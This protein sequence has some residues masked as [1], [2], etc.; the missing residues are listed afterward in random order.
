M[1]SGL[2][3]LRVFPSIDCKNNPCEPLM[4]A[5]FVQVTDME[6]QLCTELANTKHLIQ[7]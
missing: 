5:A 6:Q 2:Q 1:D 4:E 7:N 3:L